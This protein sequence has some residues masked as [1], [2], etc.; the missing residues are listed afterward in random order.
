MR[1]NE[2]VRNI[3]VWTNKEEQCLLDKIS[4]PRSL[5]TFDE[6]DRTIIETLVRKSLLIKVQGLNST[7]VYPN[8]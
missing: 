6:R 7:Y 5:D 2:L 4:E 3:S 8:T 1:L